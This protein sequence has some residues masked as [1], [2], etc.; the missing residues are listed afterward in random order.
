MSIPLFFPAVR[1]VRRLAIS[2]RART[3]RALC[4]TAGVECKASGNW[5]DRIVDLIDGDRILIAAEPGDWSAVQIS[6]PQ[7]DQRIAARIALAVMAYVLH[8]LVAKQSIMG[9]NW[10]RV[11]APRGRKRSGSALSTAERQRRYRVRHQRN[12]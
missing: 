11:S 5:T 10:S 2:K 12:D 7:Q 3:L 4:E 1:Y 9:A 8:D 6:L